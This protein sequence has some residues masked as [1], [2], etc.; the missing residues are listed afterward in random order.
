MSN[1]AVL[2]DRRRIRGLARERMAGFRALL[3]AEF[4]G[5]SAGLGTMDVM[6]AGPF[7][8]R[9][10]QAYRGRL[11]LAGDAAGF[12]DGIT[13]EG[14]SLSLLG[15]ERCAEAID[16]ALATNRTASFAAYDRQI[17]EAARNSTCLGRLSLFFAR[18]QSLAE[19]A[20]ASL[21]NRPGTFEK[22]LAINQGAAGFRTLRPANAIGLFDPRL[23]FRTRRG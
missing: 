9:V 12:F 11:V 16:V 19:V 15:A 6:S 2:S 1:V 17:R 7:P 18:H 13:G 23:L 8:V 5:R 10:R 21:A 14:I 3:D 20:I 22:L 4:E